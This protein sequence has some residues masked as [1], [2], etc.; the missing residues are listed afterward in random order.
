MLVHGGFVQVEDAR[1]FGKVI[2]SILD[3][4]EVEFFR[5]VRETE[6]ELFATSEVRRAFLYPETR[7]Y[8]RTHHGERWAMGRVRRVFFRER[9]LSDL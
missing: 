6:T 5:S 4:V 9:R 3:R 8:F 7:V 1:R 2:D